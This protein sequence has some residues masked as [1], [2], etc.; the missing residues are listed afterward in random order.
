MQKTPW[1]LRAALSLEAA[2]LVGKEALGASPWMAKRV[3]QGLAGLAALVAILSLLGAGLQT[4][5]S[6]PGVEIA[7]SPS[8]ASR[9]LW[10]GQ[11]AERPALKSAARRALSSGK[12]TLAM[13]DGA[14]VKE[15][16]SREESG[17]DKESARETEQAKA[18]VRA[19]KRGASV[20]EAAREIREQPDREPTPMA[21]AN[22]KIKAAPA[23]ELRFGEAL[24][25]QWP[26]SRGERDQAVYE[27]A[28]RINFALGAMLLALGA[29]IWVVSYIVWDLSGDARRR[30]VSRVRQRIEER[31]DEIESAVTAKE[32]ARVSRPGRKAGSARL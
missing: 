28:G 21:W 19:I 30:V 2:A 29:L 18:F 32:L 31:R 1:R 5:F 15:L 4:V 27:A 7:V 12:P 22:E 9:W 24:A 14:D 10:V 23:F 16:R 8:D 26:G 3:A 6:D 17:K 13:L 25:S 20:E 11:T